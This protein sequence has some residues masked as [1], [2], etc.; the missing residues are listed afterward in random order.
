MERLLDTATAAQWLTAHGVHRTEKTLRKLRCIGGGP[1]F[2]RLNGKPFYIE[3]D[4]TEW[5]ESRLT[6]PM[7]STSEADAA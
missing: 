1:K 3:P 7:R 5:V 6:A 4:L 2:R